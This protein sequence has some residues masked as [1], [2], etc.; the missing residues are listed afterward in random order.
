M[1]SRRCDAVSSTVEVLPYVYGLSGESCGISLVGRCELFNAERH[2][3][4]RQI[5]GSGVEGSIGAA[6]NH[7]SG[8]QTQ[9]RGRRLDTLTAASRISMTVSRPNSSCLLYPGQ[10]LAVG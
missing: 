9:A 2:D 10:A 5:H 4:T 6:L 8:R 1:T 7:A 3:T